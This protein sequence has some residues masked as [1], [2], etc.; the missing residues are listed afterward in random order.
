M[1]TTA[2]DSGGPLGR[3]RPLAAFTPETLAA[4]LEGAGFPAYRA[5]QVMNWFYKK[6]VREFAAMKN[7]SAKLVDH[8]EEEFTC[9]SSRLVAAHDG[10]DGAVKMEIGLADAE[11]VEA[12][13][14]EAGGRATLCVSSQVGCPLGC[15]FCAT[16]RGGWARDLA[17]HEIVE[18]AIHARPL[19]SRAPR[20][21]NIVYMGMGEPCLNLDAVLASVEV[22]NAPWAF[23]TGA[24]RIT[25]STLGDPECIE[26]IAEFPL[27]VGLAVS[28]HAA[29][30]RTRRRLAPGAPAGVSETV[31]AGRRYFEK[32]GREVTYEYVLLAG[33]NDSTED[34]GRLADL[35][36]GKRA[37]V[38]VIRY[39]EVEG[40]PYKRPSS[41]KAAGFVRSLE[42]R[43]V[44]ARVRRSQGRSVHAA[45]GQ[46]RLARPAGRLK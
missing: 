24:R 18:Q 12:V 44:K 7:I 21:S 33:V 45:C 20:I 22:F 29:D 19:L 15:L 37:F 1:N 40:L 26:R 13:V 16:G 2:G 31:E 34:A 3:R 30:D 32:T 35:L 39:N 17:A 42:A 36:S 11:T 25:I 41:H 10:G 4:A 14:M 23:R 6:G 28:L 8:L 46:L 38:N 43:G 5:R 27:P 9:V